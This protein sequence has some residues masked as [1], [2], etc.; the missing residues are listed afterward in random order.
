MCGRTSLFPPALELERRFD[1]AIAEG[2]DYQPRYNISPGSHVEVIT[3]VNPAQIDQF[4][5]GLIPHWA[6]HV[7]DGFINARAETAP[8]KP[9][10]R[11]AWKDRP[12]LVLSSGFYEW[13]SVNGGRTQ[14]YRIYRDEG[15]TFAMAGLWQETVVDEQRIRSVTILTTEPNDLVA[16]IHDRMP[17]VLP[18]E[19]EARWL[20]EEPDD[21][22]ALCRPYPED[23]LD[24]YEIDTQVNNPGNDDATVIEPAD[25]TQA[26]IGDFSE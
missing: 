18:R 4:H 14:P 7:D 24:A 5:W 21:R 1:A 6:D 8:E 12:C 17:V 11:D 23:D 13:R 22:H 25:R 2:V 10:F 16:P 3:N 26:G 9:A 20:G 19:D 15:P